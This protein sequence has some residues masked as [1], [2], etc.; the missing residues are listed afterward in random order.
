MESDSEKE[1]RQ[2]V[3]ELRGQAEEEKVENNRLTALLGGGAKQ[4]AKRNAYQEAAE[5]IEERI[6]SDRSER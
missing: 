4:V 2:I 1:A 3:K 5:M 6:L